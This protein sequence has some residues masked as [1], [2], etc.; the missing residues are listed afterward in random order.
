MSAILEV[1]ALNKQY[2]GS[3]FALKDVSF[4]IPYGSIVGFIGENG[5]GKSTTMGSILGTLQKDSGSI[6]IFDEEMDPDKTNIKESIGVVFDDIHLPGGITV[7]KLGQVFNNIYQQWNQKTFDYYIDFFSL[8]KKKKISGFSRGMSMKLSVAVALSH[9]AKLL[10]LDEATAGLDPT[11][12]DELLDVLKTF[13]IGE[14]RSILLSSHITSDIEKIADSLIFIKNGELL[15]KVEKETL[16]NQYA[17]LQCKQYEFEHIEKN[18]IITYKRSGDEMEVLVSDREQVPASIK[19]KAF[20][21]DDIT[22]LLM[23]GEEV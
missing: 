15:L 14:E 22:L 19:T 3:S 5:A 13:V 17:I 23:R 1:E 7:D 10:I 4:A 6:Q 9:D 18:L 2:S 11:G 21:I 8:P 16:L 12:R 20:S